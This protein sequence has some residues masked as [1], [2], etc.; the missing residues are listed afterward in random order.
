MPLDPDAEEHITANNTRLA[1]N[2]EYTVTATPGSGWYG[3]AFGPGG[4]AIGD[5]AGAPVSLSL[6]PTNNAGTIILSVTAGASSTG[7][8]E[9]Q[10]SIVAL[11]IKSRNAEQP[12]NKETHM[13][14]TERPAT[15]RS[16]Y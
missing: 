14:A 4:S 9:G 12:R 7:T 5:T 6:T 8:E 2:T 1:E 11:T 10:G 15:R 3:V 13:T 16:H